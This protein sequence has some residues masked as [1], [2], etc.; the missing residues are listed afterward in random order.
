MA[1]PARVGR[2]KV[3]VVSV[4]CLVLDYDGGATIG[5]VREQLA[6]L[7]HAGYTSFNHVRDG[8]TSKFRIVAPLTAPCPAADWEA[9]RPVLR[10]MFPGVDLR[11]FDLGRVFFTPRTDGTLPVEN[12]HAD[13]E[14]FNWTLVEPT[15]EVVRERSATVR[16]HTDEFKDAT[17]Q[18]AAKCD[19]SD[20]NDWLAW[21]GRLYDAGYDLAD[22]QRL[23]DADQ[24]SQRTCESW[25]HTLEKKTVPAGVGRLI[26][27]IRREFP[28]WSPPTE[29]TLVFVKGEPKPPEEFE[30]IKLPKPREF[31]P[32]TPANERRRLVRRF[33]SRM[34]AN[35]QNHGVL[36]TPEGYGK[37]T[38]IV[39]ELLT[40]GKD[41]LFCCLSHKQV[42]EKLADF[43]FHDPVRVWSTAAILET[44]LG[45]KAVMKPHAETDWR[46]PGMDI[47]ATADAIAEKLACTVDEAKLAIEEA[48]ERAAE[49]RR[50][51]AKLL[52]TTFSTGDALFRMNCGSLDRIVV[53]DD[54]SM[55]DLIT[56]KFAFEKVVLENEMEI[57]TSSMVPIATRPVEDVV[58]GQ[59]YAFQDK[60][61][62]TTTE[63]NVTQCLR[64]QHRT[65]MVTDIVES[66]DTDARVHMIPTHLVRKATKKILPG[67]LRAVEDDTHTDLAF[68]ANGVKGELNLV[69]TKGRN[70]LAR[71]T[72]IAISYPHPCDVAAVCDALGIGLEAQGEVR[73]QMVTDV[74]DQAIGRAQGYR[75]N[76]GTG[77]HRTLVI[78]DKDFAD[79]VVNRSRYDLRGAPEFDTS[80]QIWGFSSI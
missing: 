5:E 26:A 68:I 7:A 17:L 55:T 35:W 13:G 21:G 11:S 8:A 27:R 52:I 3:N 64:R 42:V 48:K 71:H 58:F 74:L 16:E 61:I 33:V 1:P 41:V 22:Y 65:A 57:Q 66:L 53:V 18:Q 77:G 25:W 72:V 32:C 45:I 73:K 51:K 62:W 29:P 47:D 60:V 20:R 43:A 28:D 9:R 80:A 44:E 39:D 23:S 79:A 31:F 46:D 12:W 15:L 14:P 37:S 70:D 69:N 78:V 67:I 38:T 6:G 40:R 59:E 76:L 10:E 50:S 4:S 30:T 2:R 54:P 34:L 75:G 56:T 36:R 19:W 63:Q 49:S 24:E